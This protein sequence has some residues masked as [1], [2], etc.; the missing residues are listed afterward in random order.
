MMVGART[1]Q[2]RKL[3]SFAMHCHFEVSVVGR[4]DQ[5]NGG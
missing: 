1:V 3:L 4:E 2:T 5:V